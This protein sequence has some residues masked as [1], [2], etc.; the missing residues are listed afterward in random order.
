MVLKLL[1]SVIFGGSWQ[2]RVGIHIYISVG[3]VG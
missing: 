2:Y 3:V 1:L